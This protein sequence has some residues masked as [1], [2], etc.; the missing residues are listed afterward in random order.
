MIWNLLDGSSTTPNNDGGAGSIVM[1]VV[2]AVAIIGLFVW[3]SISNKKKQKQAQ[4]MVDNIKLGCRIKTIGGICGFL[5]E[6]NKKDNTIVLE[7]GT[8]SNKSYI[9]FDRNA[10]YQVGDANGEKTAVKGVTIEAEP[11]E[12]KVETKEVNAEE[13]ATE[14]EEVKTEVAEKPKKAKKSKKATEEEK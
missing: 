3:S 8:A 14:K 11:V 2:I 10:I 4:E 13:K 5:V 9:R 7:T 12:A 6:I 1:L